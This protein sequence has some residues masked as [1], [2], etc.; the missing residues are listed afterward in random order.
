MMQN[1]L[2]PASSWSQ[3]ALRPLG[4]PLHA[5]LKFL[6]RQWGK[7]LP[8]GFCL[9]L[10]IS[11]VHPAWAQETESVGDAARAFRARRAAQANQDTARRARSPVSA[12]T[13]V[14]W[15][16]AGMAAPDVLNEI[17]LRGI[18]FVLDD[19]H[20]NS[21]KDAGVAPEVLVAL[22]NVPSHP[23]PSSS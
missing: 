2:S 7:C 20:L 21:L 13:L 15:Q 10:V 19:A 14:A 17:Q 23:D 9:V 8:V 6:C 4:I 18:T 16:I 11:A 12:K 22:P 3:A 1:F 5:P